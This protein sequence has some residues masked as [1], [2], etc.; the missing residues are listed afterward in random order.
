MT[1]S[2]FKL[3]LFNEEYG[4][5]STRPSH[6]LQITGSSELNKL[7]INNTGPLLNYNDLILNKTG[8]LL[9]YNDLILNN[10]GP[11][12][13]YNELIMDNTGPLLN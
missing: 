12:S 11:L 8:P 9:N 5:L 1:W 6:L 10:T 4:E 7:I 3:E 2:A 13:N